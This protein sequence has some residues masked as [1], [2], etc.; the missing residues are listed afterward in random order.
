MSR[1]AGKRVVLTGASGGIGSEV[2]RMLVKRGAKI[3]LVG[4]GE[5]GLALLQSELQQTESSRKAE[6]IYVT[7]DVTSTE[8]RE[9]VI[10]HALSGMGGVDLLINLAGA[11]SFT[12]FSNEA[13]EITEQLF[14]VNVLAPMHLSRMIIPHMVE[15]GSG[16]IV[17]VGS[18]FGSIAFAWFTSYSSTKFALRG[19]SEALRRE[20][21]GTGVTVTYIAP[22]AVR[23]SFN[24]DQVT[25]MCQQLK[26]NM[27]EPDEVASMI[28][29]ALESGAKDTYLGFPEKLFVRINSLF[30]RLVDKALSG[31]NREAKRYIN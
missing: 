23:T 13:P 26:M 21:D 24:S 1:L 12:E 11:M 29:G 17:N 16:Q 14:R 9:S 15:K 28:V 27:D 10:E 18:I 6:I 8:D 19:F 5:S 31:Q 4:R 20:L 2:A 25:E 30:P 7:A 3:V 22:R